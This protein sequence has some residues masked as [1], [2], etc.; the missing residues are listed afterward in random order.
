MTRAQELGISVFPYREFDS[1]GNKTYYENS[2]LGWYKKEFDSNSREIYHEDSKG[3]WYKKEYDSDGK[4]T[5]YV[6]SGGFW[7]KYDFNNERCFHWD[8]DG[9]WEITDENN[10][11]VESTIK[12]RNYP[13]YAKALYS[14]MPD[15]MIIKHEHHIDWL[16]LSFLPTLSKNIIDKYSDRLDLNIVKFFNNNTYENK[17]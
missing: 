15:D 8:S 11:T 4:L 5:Y 1:N 13:E 16:I 10:R 3:D 17:H 9:R 2:L 12:N 7:E 6:D 14:H